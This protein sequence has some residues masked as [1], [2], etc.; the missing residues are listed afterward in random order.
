M[1]F[2]LTYEGPLP[3]NGNP[4]QKHEIRR[5][6]HPQLRE[7]WSTHPALKPIDYLLDPTAINSV[8]FSAGAFN[9]ASLICEELGLLAAID[10]LLLR[11]GRPGAVISSRA[12]LDNQIKTL[13]DALRVPTGS[14]EVPDSVSPMKDEEPFFCLLDDDLRVVDLRV[15]AEQLL[16]PPPTSS[17]VRALIRVHA[18]VEVPR[19]E[20]SAFA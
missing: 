9:F 14:N 3:S 10:V 4:T 11:P 13:F 8:I 16:I 1:E 18:R 12:D 15:R 6:F 5:A 17:G 7:L 2:I 20:N 19:M